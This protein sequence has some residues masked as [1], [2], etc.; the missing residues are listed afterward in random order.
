M[1]RNE[2]KNGGLEVNKGNRS[3]DGG[4]CLEHDFPIVFYVD[5]KVA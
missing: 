1:V 3:Q 5:R 2:R 4:V